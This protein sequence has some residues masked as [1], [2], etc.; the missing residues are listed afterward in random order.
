V[1]ALV[2]AHDL[3][4]I[5]R[6]RAAGPR[7]GL[8]GLLGG[9]KGSGELAAILSRRRRSRARRVGIKKGCPA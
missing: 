4:E 5:Q 8:A 2:A 7:A 6:L 3:E 9:W 1:A